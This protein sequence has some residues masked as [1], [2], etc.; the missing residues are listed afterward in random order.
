MIFSNEDQ[1]Q[2]Q[3]VRDYLDNY[4]RVRAYTT[5]ADLKARGLP[6]SPRY[7]TLLSEL[8]T[9]W[10]DGKINTYEE[11]IALLERLLKSE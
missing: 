9:A 4:R 11:E 2:V 7:D 6:P 1:A 3:P 8:H 10:L 5:G